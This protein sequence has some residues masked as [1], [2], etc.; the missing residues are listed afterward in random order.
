MKYLDALLEW[1]T[2]S[3]LMRPARAL[4]IAYGYVFRGEK[5]TTPMKW[6]DI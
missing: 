6:S 5:V 3:A 2:T 1:H 4:S